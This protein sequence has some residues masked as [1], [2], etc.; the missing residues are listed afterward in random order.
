MENALKHSGA[1]ELPISLDRE[2]RSVRLAVQDNGKGIQTKK[3]GKGMGL[4]LMR[5]RTMGLGGA[6]HIE[7]LPEGGTRIAAVVPL[8]QRKKRN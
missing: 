2:G 5:Y 1:T 7:R 6:F 8:S 4:H 3:R